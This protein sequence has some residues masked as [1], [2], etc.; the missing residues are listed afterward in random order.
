YVERKIVWA[1]AQIWAG[2]GKFEPLGPRTIFLGR[3]ERQM[4]LPI[5]R[6]NHNFDMQALDVADFAYIRGGFPYFC[7]FDLWLS[8][9]EKVNITPH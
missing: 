9:N 7:K 1:E 2:G 8:Q 3:Q 5:T 6:K 4:Y